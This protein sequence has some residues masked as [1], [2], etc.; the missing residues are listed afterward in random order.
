MAKLNTLEALFVDQLQ[1][2]YDAEN[3]ITKALPKMMK[4][5]TAPELKQSF[6]MHL[7]QTKNQIARLEQI[8]KGMNAKPQGKSCEAMQGLI[9][10][11]EELMSHKADPAVMDAGLIA[12]AQ[13][14]EHY[15]MA[16]YGCVRTWAQRL[17]HQEAA[18]LLQQTLQEEEQ[19][20][21]N[22]TQL[23]ERVINIE[24]AGA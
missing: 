18:S 11:G 4:A 13:K 15:E 23:A 14:V 19:T 1:D 21:K 24:A 6:E 3:Q 2:L 12:T 17:G 8:F 10:E 22:L 7:E 20:D 9:K 16:G 5:A